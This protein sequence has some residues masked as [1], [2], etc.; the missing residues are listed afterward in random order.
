MTL[1][2]GHYR[3]LKRP[4]TR[5]ELIADGLVHGTALVAALVALSILIALVAL[6]RSP[7]EVAAVAVYGFALIAM[8]SISAVYNMWPVSPTKWILRRFDHS[9][10]Y[11]LIA[12]TYTPL[13][14]QVQDPFW[15]AFLAGVVWSGAA[16]GIL[17]KL[18]WPGRF[19][20]A[21]LVIYLLLGWVAVSALEPLSASLSFQAL[22]LVAA[23]GVLYSTGV[24]FHV[25]H[26]LKFQNVIWHVFV[27][28]AA[29]CHYAA[30]ATALT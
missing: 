2:Q 30:I 17:L 14:T 9:A 27:V 18:A 6:R 3:L 28:T 26:A 25:W 20:R 5:A 22:V 11:V 21:S 29:A 12:G 8:L 7:G 16:V 13:L 4:Y 10:I 24:I 15:A 23:G 19:D 1:P